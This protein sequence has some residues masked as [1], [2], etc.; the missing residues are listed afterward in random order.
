[1]IIHTPFCQPN[2][3]GV[4]AMG[5]AWWV[6]FSTCLI[7]FLHAAKAEGRPSA[8]Q[9]PRAAERQGPE[10]YKKMR[11]EELMNVEVT[12]VSRRPQKLTEAASA[13]Q[14]ITQEDIRR[15]GATRLPEVLRLA[16]NLQVDHIDSGQWAI[17]A[18]GFNS[19]LANKM[20][21][22]IDGRTIYSPLFAGVFW[23]A[24]DVLLEDI[25]RIEV[26]SGPGATL[27]GANA[28]NGVINI[29]TKSAKNTQGAFLEGGGG[30]EL[31]GF[32]G[33]RFGGVVASKLYFRIYGKFTDRD[34]AVSRNGEDVGNDYR[35]GQGGF[36][37]D[38]EASENNLLTLQG[39][40]Y[41]NRMAIRGMNNA[42]NSGGNVLGRW[43]HTVSE[44]S[45]LK[46]QLYFDRARRDFPGQYGDGLNTYDVDFQ[47]RFPHGDR[48]DIVW[49]AGYRLVED[50]F[51]PRA[52]ALVPQRRSL[53]KFS[54]FAQD[55]I[56][57]VKD[58]LHLTLG[59]KLEHNDYTGFEVQPSVR[60][61]WRLNQRQT[62]WG[63]IS[64]AVRTP[65]RLDRNLVILP[66]TAGSPDFASE[67]LLAY[68]LGYR[69]QAYD[70]LSL[71]LAT[72]YNDYD[73]IRSVEQVNPPAPLPLAFGNGQKGKS[74]GAE[75][76]AEYR[77]TDWWRLRA[78]YTELR[79]HLHRKP[80][81]TDIN[82]GNSEAADSNHH[83]L[84]RSSLDLPRHLELDP[85]F[86]YVSRVTNRT[87]DVPGY[88]ELDLRLA[89][90][91]TTILEFSVVGQNLLHKRHA[92]FGTATMRQ[93]IERSVYGKLTFWW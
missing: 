56:A 77:V 12:S 57:L 90:R 17:S 82:S 85:T 69:V 66:V 84:L 48:N 32:G 19:S 5:M 93:E 25:E 6:G 72:F 37:A 7:A 83:F 53:Q 31:R 73:D 35:M 22:L 61:A 54:T 67:T 1:M 76:T 52:V 51:S 8:S 86:R 92:E 33:G 58:R 9:A 81:S 34:G 80:G 26:I 45:D 13:I 60:L 15:S 70:Q 28:V 36:R 27:W 24:Q 4:A 14:V 75:W 20:L 21:V 46:L 78:G 50:N 38:W 23:D 2:P 29:T 55:E 89:W 74:Y 88:N 30:A 65:S 62:L 39:D 87:Q 10:T 11:L 40:I 18:R 16:S 68:E 44:D 42:V 71:S 91:P 63:A 43:S 64:R 59:T 41:E 3:P 47:H 49:G 79:V